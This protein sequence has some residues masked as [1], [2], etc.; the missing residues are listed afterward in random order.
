MLQVHMS[1][2]TAAQKLSHPLPQPEAGT[3]PET[4]IERNAASTLA[5]CD[6]QDDEPR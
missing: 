1:V 4:L 6:T 3:T 5:I 2:Q